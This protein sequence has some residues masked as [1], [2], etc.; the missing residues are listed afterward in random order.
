MNQATPLSVCEVS[1]TTVGRRV[2][3]RRRDRV[4]KSGLAAA[5]HRC[6]R[7]AVAPRIAAPN[8]F[9]AI[10]ARPNGRSHFSGRRAETQPLAD[11]IRTIVAAYVPTLP[12]E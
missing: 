3:F 1:I 2:I 5:R 11:V 4:K 8:I 9:I 12:R 6:G 10:N 7:S